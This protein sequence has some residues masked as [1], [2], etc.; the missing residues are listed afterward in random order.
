MAAKR[1]KVAY[2]SDAM[3]RLL[4]A[5]SSELMRAHFQA[6]L[7]HVSVSPFHIIGERLVISTCNEGFSKNQVGEPNISWSEQSAHPDQCG[8]RVLK[9]CTLA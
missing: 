2:L 1:T 4:I 8:V 5:L 9:A 3:V 6:R 7:G